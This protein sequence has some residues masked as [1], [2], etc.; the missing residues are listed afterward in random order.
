MGADH[1]RPLLSADEERHLARQIEAGVLAEHLLVT[2]ERPVPVTEAELSQLAGAGRAAWEHF[3]LAHLRL[4]HK[5]A[6]QEARRSGLPFDDLFQEGCLALAGA[7][8]RFDPDRG[9]F[10]RYAAGCIGRHLSA[11]AASR[12]GALGLPVSEAIA[13]RR[14][15]GVL[16]ELAQERL[17]EVGVPELAQ[18]LGRDA[19][20]VQRWLRHRAPTELPGADSLGAWDGSCLDPDRQILDAQV[21]REV[22][23]LSPELA[24]VVRLRFGI[25]R[26]EPLDTGIL[27]ERL[28]MSVSTARRRELEALAILRRRL[29][30]TGTGADALAG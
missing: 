7:L 11:L 3:W 22:A 19:D 29:A 2:G 28:G 17:E 8:Q 15:R 30:L 9:R 26:S 5:L 13:V 27:A 12:L 20:Q 18:R 10:F 4:V 6:R 14:A 1:E 23:R 25:G 16:A 21:R 24:M